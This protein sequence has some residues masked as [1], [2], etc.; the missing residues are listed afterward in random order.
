MSYGRFFLCLWVIGSVV[1]LSGCYPQYTYPASSVVESIEKIC[2]EEHHLEV[3]ARV[4][5]GTV[6]ALFYTDHLL[7]PESNELS[8]GVMDQ[9]GDVSQALARVPLSTDL[10]LNFSVLVVRDKQTYDELIITRSV[11]DLKRSQVDAL[12]VDEYMKRVLF[13]QSRYHPQVEEKDNFMLKEVTMEDFL[14]DQ[15]SQRIRL[16]M[17]GAPTSEKTEASFHTL[18]D[19]YFDQGMG[20]GI[21]RFSVISFGSDAGEDPLKK[22]IDTTDQVL[23]GY[24]FEE[25]DRIEIQ[26]L[27]NRRKLTMTPQVLKD[28]HDKKIKVDEIFD[29]YLKEAA[30]IREALE[31]F[32]LTSEPK[33]PED[34]NLPSPKPF[35]LPE[36]IVM[37]G[38]P[39]K[40]RHSPPDKS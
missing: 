21:F 31:L 40:K 19:G 1:S 38:E 7:N 20:E 37:P 22:I 28:Y 12:S 33:G 10:K 9:I 30:S 14:A 17:Q 18:V 5:G 15:I 13:K 11:E 6:G 35:E 26:D 23:R 25:Y 34:V 4:A 2:K 24:R 39:R 27:M 3:N 29:R 8:K 16:A 32:G 36:E